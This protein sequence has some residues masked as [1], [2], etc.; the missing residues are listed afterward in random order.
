MRHI[1]FLFLI[2]ILGCKDKNTNQ[3]DANQAAILSLYGADISFLPA[4]EKTGFQF[5]DAKGNPKP[6]LLQL[7]DAH[8][9]LIRLRIWVNPADS[10]AGNE[11][12]KLLN[13]QA[14]ALG[15]KTL[16]SVHYSDTWA[17]PS[18]QSIPSNWSQTNLFL[19]KK[20]VYD[21]TAQL[22]K[23]FQPDY[24]QI[25]NEINNGFLWPL[26]HINQPSQF[27]SCIDTAILA[28][29]KCSPQTKIVLHYAGH[30]SA[31]WFFNLFKQTD[32]DVIGLSY[33]PN[34]HGKSIDT[35]VMNMNAL[36]I[37]YN[38]SVFICETA[39]PFTLSWNDQTHNVIGLNSQLIPE[40]P[41]TPAGQKAY[42]E[43]LIKQIKPVKNVLG[44]CYWGA[45]WVSYKGTQSTQGS[46]W[47]N[48]AW[49][50]FTGKALPVLEWMH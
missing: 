18:A 28:V 41:A 22:S 9:N 4:I 7:K 29:R 48:Q 33:Y 36:A 25:G 42:M 46:S 19:L 15:F 20:Q 49:F 37:A 10:L 47:E 43:A 16:L 34:W 26:G 39:Y 14:K 5:L 32:Y 21:Y 1:F 27:V 44:I 2:F 8:I 6:L 3:P 17:D 23:E 45:E 40:F 35:L 12:M 13:F 30:S 31:K 50:D 38:K 11:T 24:I